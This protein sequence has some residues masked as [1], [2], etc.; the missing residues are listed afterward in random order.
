MTDLQRSA[1]EEVLALHAT[2]TLWL[3]QGDGDLTHL[4]A[5]MAPSFQMIGPNG[6]MLARADVLAALRVERGRRGKDF[7][8]EIH[9]ARA[10]AV[11]REHVLVV[12]IEKQTDAHSTTSR[13]SSALFVASACAPKG[14]AWLHLQETWLTQAP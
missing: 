12:Y 7:R 2:F 9:G 14:V 11:G 3:G 1:L 5:A 8:I 6:S 10:F 4:D 13:R